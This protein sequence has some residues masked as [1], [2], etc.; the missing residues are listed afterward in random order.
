MKQGSL[1]TRTIA[2]IGVDI[3]KWQKSSNYNGNGLE[4]ENLGPYEM[5]FEDWSCDR[6]VVIRSEI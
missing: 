3:F 5:C 4:E 2:Y 1:E 6:L